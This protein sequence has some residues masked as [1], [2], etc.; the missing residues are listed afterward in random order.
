MGTGGRAAAHLGPV[1]T[2]RRTARGSGMSLTHIWSGLT[3]GLASG[4]ASAGT[5][6]TRFADRVGEPAGVWPVAAVAV[7][8]V[9][10]AVMALRAGGA[11]D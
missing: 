3:T 11:E 9:V 6:L 1:G 2:G 8:A 10:I 7:L 4:L 5:A